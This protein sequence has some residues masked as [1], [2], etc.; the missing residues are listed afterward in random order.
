MSRAETPG[1]GHTHSLMYHV[2]TAVVSHCLPCRFRLPESGVSFS[3]GRSSLTAEAFLWPH[4]T[5]Y[6]IIWFCMYCRC[7]IQLVQY[8]TMCFSVQSCLCCWTGIGRWTMHAMSGI[9]QWQYFHVPISFGTNILTWK[10]CWATWQVS[11]V[12]LHVDIC[13]LNY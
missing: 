12:L 2:F 6:C 13:S 7:A 10:R 1:E 4:I 3:Y 9:V 5:T 11:V 8:N